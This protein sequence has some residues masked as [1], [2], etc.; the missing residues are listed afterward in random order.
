LPEQVKASLGDTVHSTQ[1]GWEMKAWDLTASGAEEQTRAA[2][3]LC[4]SGAEQLSVIFPDDTFN[5][6]TR[7]R[8]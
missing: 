8:E 3:R 2:E 7:G 5:P 1:P 4:A 6:L